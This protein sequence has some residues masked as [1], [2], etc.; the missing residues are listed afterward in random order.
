MEAPDGELAAAGP[1]LAGV[2]AALASGVS[3][4]RDATGWIMSHGLAEPNDALAGRRHTYGCLAWSSADGCWHGQRLPRLS[5]CPAR[6]APTPSSSKTRSAPP[7]ST[8]SSSCP[9]P[10][11][12]S[13]RS[14]PAPDRSSRSISAGRPSG[15][16]RLW[17]ITAVFRGGR[18]TVHAVL[19]SGTPSACRPLTAPNL[20]PSLRWRSSAPLRNLPQPAIRHSAGEFSG[21]SPSLRERAGP[22][23]HR[24]SRLSTI[25]QAR[26]RARRY[27]PPECLFG[28]GAWRIA[29]QFRGL[30]VT[31]LSLGG[32][33]AEPV[34][35][36]CLVESCDLSIPVTEVAVDGPGPFKVPGRDSRDSTESA[37]SPPV[38]SCQ[39]SRIARAHGRR[40]ASG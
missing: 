10:P 34:R 3:A 33:T 27:H 38:V 28:R 9:R 22:G 17:S 37:C 15:K 18:V 23:Q 40:V 4:L 26:P 24:I 20:A 29:G 35:R 6:A 1:E 25:A 7:G 32:F 21:Y 5:C 36:P 14:P 11:A 39:S 31:R 2:R 8:L 16:R 13:P 19:N 12:C 30:L